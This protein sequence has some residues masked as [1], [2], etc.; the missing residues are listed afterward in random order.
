MTNYD[1][2]SFKYVKTTKALMKNFKK[3]IG[4]LPLL[5]GIVI[6]SL[7]FVYTGNLIADL[8]YM[9]IDPRVKGGSKA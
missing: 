3:F 9:L 8:I 2:D 7:I 4:D 5:M 6:I 1:N